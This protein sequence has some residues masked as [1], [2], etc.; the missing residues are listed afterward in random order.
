[1]AR[2]ARHRAAHQFGELR[3]PQQRLPPTQGLNS[4]LDMMQQPVSG[5]AVISL[6]YRWATKLSLQLL[7]GFKLW[8]QMGT[9]LSAIRRNLI[10]CVEGN[11]WET[12]VVTT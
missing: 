7:I 12:V 5:S 9:P 1:M 8:D 2:R 11:A 6:M 3:G 4:S 10:H